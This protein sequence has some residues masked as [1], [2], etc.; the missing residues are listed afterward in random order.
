LLGDEKIAQN[1][2]IIIGAGPAGSTAARIMAEA[3]LK[4]LV[5]EKE[6]LGRNK[7]CAGA[8][9]LR[10]FDELD[11]DYTDFVEREISGIRLYSPDNSVM[12]HD[13]GRTVGITVYREQFDSHLLQLAINAGAEVMT[14]TSARDIIKTGDSCEISFETDNK[15]IKSKSGK[16][17][18]A[19]DGVFSKI[20]KKSGLYRY[21]KSQLGICVQYEMEMKEKDINEMIGDNVEIYF[22]SSIAPDGYGWIFPKKHGVTVGVGFSL[23]ERKRKI[24]DYLD[25]FVYEHPIASNKLKSARIYRK[26]GGLVPM[27][28][29]ISQTYDDNIL[30][31]GDAAGQV[32]PLIAEGIYYSM[33]CAKVAAHVGMEAVLKNNFSA[34]NL[35]KYEKE[36]K[37]IIGGDLKRGNL[38]NNLLL[39]EDRRINYLVNEA[40]SS[41]DL[42]IMIA[43]IIAGMGSL[44]EIIKRN[45]STALSYYCKGL[46]KGIYL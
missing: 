7:P 18:I 36:W 6:R 9:T 10:A 32:S 15:V 21:T 24:T 27:K 43:D 45:Y 44:D 2:V 33:I 14:N 13:Y 29:V 46:I 30:V 41:K 16:I 23:S 35:K 38:L 1:D 19:A 11:I 40:G 8:I 25:L 28:G 26:T 22:G 34:N 17:I 4:V 20:S 42:R 39:S 5:I 12:E 31:V 3:G 37:K